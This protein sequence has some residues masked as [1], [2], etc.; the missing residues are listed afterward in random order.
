VNTRFRVAGA[1][2]L[3]ASC[4][5]ALCGCGS[6]ERGALEKP[7]GGAIRLSPSPGYANARLA[8]V[9][10][11]GAPDP[12]GCRFEW[13]RNGTRI[14]G[15]TGRELPPERFRRGDHIL[16]RVVTPSAGA[17]SQSWTA[18]TPVV[19]SAPQ[20][21]RVT[22]AMEDEPAGLALHA[23]V[24]CA[25]VDGDTPRLEYAWFRNGDP[26]E[27]ATGSSVLVASLQRGDRVTVSVVA[28]DFESAAPP[29]QSEAFALENHAP[30][31]TSQPAA[32]GP[33]DD[34]FA[35]RAVAADPDGDAL[36]YELVSGPRGLT[37]SPEGQVLWTLPDR[38][39]RRG[40]FTVRIRATDSHGG[41]AVQ[42]F[43][44]RIGQAV[45]VR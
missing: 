34:T 20:V 19:N 35:Y 25:D 22:I 28:R 44:L 10:G 36:R 43:T 14:E 33:A 4:A 41:E 16:V 5:L 26:I 31:F 45:A 2:V 37:V 8:V 15:E 9:F 42:E 18:Q 7:S 39:A 17:E 11:E 32:P 3:V 24:E 29:A 12:A 1:F 30:A 21:S 13:R 23:V 38:E 6:V 40:D 27:S